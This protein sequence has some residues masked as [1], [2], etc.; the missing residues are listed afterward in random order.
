M[1][2]PLI[3]AQATTG[4]TS[5]APASKVIKL[6]KPQTDQALTV[7]VD[8][9]AKIDFTDIAN[10]KITLVRVGDRLVILFEGGATVSV[11]PF[12]DPTGKPPRTASSVRPSLR[13][14]F[15]SPAISRYCRPRAIRRH[16]RRRRTSISRSQLRR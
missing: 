6:A 1:N 4:Q 10:E 3:M 2:R 9:A 7:N 16:R 11:G 14:C 15:R 8:G 12:F 13:R 5:G